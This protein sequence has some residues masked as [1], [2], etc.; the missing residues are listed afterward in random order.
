VRFIRYNRKSNWR[1][2]SLAVGFLLLSIFLSA[3]AAEEEAR[4]KV[5]EILIQ[6]I[7]ATAA[8]T[9]SYTRDVKPLLVDN[10][11]ECHSPKDHKG[12]LDASTVA[13]MLKGGK[14]AGASII[15]GKPDD[16]PLIQYVRGLKLPQMP[17]GSPALDPKELHLLREWIAAGARD[18][19]GSVATT[20][21]GAVTNEL[22]FGVGG[23]IK[24]NAALQQAL[25]VALHGTNGTEKLIARRQLRIAALPPS[26]V[27]PKLSAPGLNEVDAFLEDS[28][29]KARLP[30]F[31]QPPAVCDDATFVRRVYL[32][33]IGVIPTVDEA[34]EF[35]DSK[36]RE[37]RAQVVDNLL[38]RKK[39]YAAHWTPFWEEAI[40]SA[41][42]DK[43][44]GIASRGN[45]RDWIFK[46]FEENKPFDLLVAELID[47]TLPGYRKPIIS[48]ANGKRVVA[49]FIRNESHV[50]T[51]QS[52]A[53]VGQ[54][55]MGTG[56]KCASCHSHFLN[57]EWPQARFLAFAGMFAA[58]DLELIRCE[59]PS[60]EFIPARFPFDV[61][62]ELLIDPMNP[63][64]SRTIVNR[65]WKRYF[66]LGL[67]E[68]QDDF[69]LDRTASQPELLEWLANDFMRH[70]Y[71]LKHTIRLLLTSRAYQ[72]RFDPALE[73]HFDINK[74]EQSARYY[75]SPSL[76]RLTAE[77]LLDSVQMALNQKLDPAKRVYSDKSS[78]AL[79]RA[80]GKPAAH[81]EI[82]T[83]RPDDVAVVQA[84]ELLNGEEWHTRIYSTAEKLPIADDLAPQKIVDR[85]YWMTLSRP[86]KEQEQ[87]R[88]ARFIQDSAAV[89][90]TAEFKTL[91]QNQATAKIVPIS[92][93]KNSSGRSRLAL[94]DILW[95]LLVSP[96]F[97]YIR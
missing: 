40:A 87:A 19:S 62:A 29:D 60:G 81:N 44:G 28:W 52:A 31:K 12:G 23:A 46:S 89:K 77:Q 51:I 86:A 32:D 90:K 63:R 1:L 34:K 73:D 9:V 27:V 49:A 97:Q 41:N 68:P 11:L 30:E 91:E 24:T 15:P 21:S 43:V 48:E 26:P 3:G 76:R 55:F 5:V 6:P 79:T 65:L 78:T 96:E 4:K 39:D 35:I 16:S 45:H 61:A 37:K 42:V 72:L 18:D 85:F 17:K 50:D 14:K 82:S 8:A 80:L 64:F 67:F 20:A 75:R 10:C 54:V 22:D 57:K 7:D 58:K 69:R 53:V 36:A 56:M 83:A 94:G 59:K 13:G 93:E 2:S 71:D 25:E 66:G 33:V 47:P 92:G 88:G 38:A 74:T 70:G 95:A 84:L